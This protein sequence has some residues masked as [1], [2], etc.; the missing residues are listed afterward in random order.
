[1]QLREA[2]ARERRKDREDRQR[3]KD[4]ESRRK[5]EK[6]QESLQLSE[7]Q[8]SELVNAIQQVLLRQARKNL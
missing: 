3:L 1:M 7:T 8:V 5:Q 6:E 2:E 4:D